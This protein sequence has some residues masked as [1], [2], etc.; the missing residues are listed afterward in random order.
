M[1][2]RGQGEKIAILH[3]F[4]T[5]SSSVGWSLHLY[6]EQGSPIL[7][8]L[9]SICLIVYHPWCLLCG[10][11]S[12]VGTVP[13]TLALLQDVLCPGRHL[14]DAWIDLK[15]VLDWCWLLGFGERLAFLYLVVGSFDLSGS[16][17]TLV[18]LYSLQDLM[19]YRGLRIIY[20]R[21][22]PGHTKPDAYSEVPTAYDFL[23]STIHSWTQWICGYVL[24]SGYLEQIGEESDSSLCQL[25]CMV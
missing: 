15:L 12:S 3:V 25:S 21:D 2:H 14:D 10:S 7:A 6:L 22:I 18:K 20:P 24:S 4:C 13:F 11:T 1:L 23:N 19:C 5:C 8:C 16:V 17:N 9:Y